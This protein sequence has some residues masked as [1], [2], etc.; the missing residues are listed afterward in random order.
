[1]NTNEEIVFNPCKKCG[2]TEYDQCDK[3]TI[4]ELPD[5]RLCIEPLTCDC[6]DLMLMAPGNNLIH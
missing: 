1:M 4:T 3:E 5:G 6:C 2:S